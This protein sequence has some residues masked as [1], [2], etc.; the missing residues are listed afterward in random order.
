MFKQPAAGRARAPEIQPPY[1]FPE[2]PNAARDDT[3]PRHE[4]AAPAAAAR[5]PEIQIFLASL[6]GSWFIFNVF[7]PHNR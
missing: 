3:L 4:T 6:S 2:A 1:A 5:P 7:E